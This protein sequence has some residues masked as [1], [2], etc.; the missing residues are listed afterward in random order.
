MDKEP[1]KPIEINSCDFN[2]NKAL[3]DF[4]SPTSDGYGSDIYYSYNTSSTS[5]S[6]KILETNPSLLVIDCDFSNGF[7][8]VSGGSIYLSVQDVEATRPIEITKCTFKESSSLEGG[9]VDIHSNKPV[10]FQFSECEFVGKCSL[11]FKAVSGLVSK[12]NFTDMNEISAIHYDCYASESSSPEKTFKVDG[13]NFVQKNEITSLV[14]FVPKAS[15]NFEFSSNIIN[16]SNN[17]TCVFDCASGVQLAGTWKFTNN[18]ISPAEEKYLNTEN[19]KSI[20]LEASCSNGFDCKA[21][22]PGQVCDG[23]VRCTG[24]GNDDQI[25]SVMISDTK[26][27]RFDHDPNGGAVEL[28]NY[29]IIANRTVFEYCTAN[30]GGGGAIYIYI[31]KELPEQQVYLKDLTFTSN[32]AI[33]G[34]GVF[35]YCNQDSMS[36]QIVSCQFVSNVAS[37][38]KKPDQLYGGAALYMKTKNGDV[39]SCKFSKNIGTGVKIYND[40]SETT[41]KSIQSMKSLLSFENCFFEMNDK[42]SSSLYYVHVNK[43]N[44]DVNVKDCV[45]AGKLAKDA[46]HI[47]G[48]SLSQKVYSPKINIESCKFS[49]DEKTAMNLNPKLVKFDAKSQQFNFNGSKNDNND[50]QKSSDNLMLISVV[51]MALAVVVA[52]LVLV[53]AKLNKETK[54]N[55]NEDSEEKNESSMI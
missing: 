45:F 4:E 35:I 8:N 6:K 22:L 40:F 16:I 5:S 30:Q 33:Y 48:V 51:S 13:C 44:A 10:L 47:D 28:I 19:A 15:S 52:V 12:C 20:Q 2:T 27:N 42:S 43:E 14:F 23:T 25:S 11:F 55:E 21:N 1:L 9:A 54:E 36:I 31:D 24:N 50:K 38:E 26:F 29:G 39:I 32:Q 37:K 34:G 41:T 18:A 7:A 53:M 3:S 17:V 46:H 49:T